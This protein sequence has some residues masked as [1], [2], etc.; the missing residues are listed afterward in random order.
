[1]I[2]GVLMFA[3]LVAFLS[4]ASMTFVAEM[5]EGTSKVMESGHTLILGWNECTLR[6][7]CQIAFLRKAWMKQNSTWDRRLF[8][9]R[10]VKPSTPVASATVVIVCNSMTKIAMEDILR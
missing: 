5:N 4:E 9:W 1:M 2:T 7:V 8:P 3:V 6:C 10:R